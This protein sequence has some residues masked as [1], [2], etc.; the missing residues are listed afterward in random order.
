MAAEQV[1]SRMVR[2]PGVSS[3]FG[4]TIARVSTQDSSRSGVIQVT[5][6]QR[7]RFVTPATMAVAGVVVLISIVFGFAYGAWWLFAVAAA[8]TTLIA[9]EWG[10]ADPDPD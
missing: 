1:E 8:L 7:E 3:L 4:W 2:V 10:E 5:Q 9:V 6:E